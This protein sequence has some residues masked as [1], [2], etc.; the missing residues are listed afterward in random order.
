MA[1]TP[2]ILDIPRQKFLFA[3]QNI[4]VS[5]SVTVET[6]V[7]SATLPGGTLSANGILQFYL[8]FA[9]SATTTVRIKYGGTTIISINAGATSG[10]EYL[11]GTMIN[12][13]SL[14]AQYASGS[15]YNSST[16]SGSATIN[17]AV[18]QTIQVTLQPLSATS[19]TVNSIEFGIFK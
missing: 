15:M 2:N 8:A 13:N 16:V 11:F 1:D 4:A 3:R 18:D 6:S 10:P 14:V 9:F 7:F 19:Q 5:V 17:S 12:R